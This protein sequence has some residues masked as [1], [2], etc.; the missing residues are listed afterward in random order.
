MREVFRVKVDNDIIDSLKF[1]DVIGNT[2]FNKNGKRKAGRPRGTT[3]KN[4]KLYVTKYSG[5]ILKT[6]QPIN[7]VI[8]R[9]IITELNK[10]V[11]VEILFEDG[12]IIVL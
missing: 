10:G 1:D 11:I 9:I 2:Q 7:D 3:N 8:S 4:K 6:F 5:I 12:S